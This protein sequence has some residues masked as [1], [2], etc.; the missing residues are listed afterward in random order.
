VTEPLWGAGFAY[1][2]LGERMSAQGVLGAGMILASAALANA[3]QMGGGDGA[4]DSPGPGPGPG[5]EGVL[6]DK[7]GCAP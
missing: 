5:V 6:A 2:A 4:G 3:A 7:R 1:L